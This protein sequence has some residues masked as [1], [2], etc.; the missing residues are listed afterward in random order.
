[1]EVCLLWVLCSAKQKSL[2][3]ADHSSRGVLPK[4]GVSEYDHEA[5][6]MRRPRPAGGCC[7]MV[8][9]KSLATIYGELFYKMYVVT[10]FRFRVCCLTLPPLTVSLFSSKYLSMLRQYYNLRPQV[11][12]SF[13][14]QC[15]YWIRAIAVYGMRILIKISVFTDIL[16]LNCCS[17]LCVTPTISTNVNQKTLA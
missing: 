9:R 16:T 13:Q 17:T 5:S 2:R 15:G 7:A 12:L 10:G 3:L 14:A 6:I 8:K 4:C 11:T 1:M